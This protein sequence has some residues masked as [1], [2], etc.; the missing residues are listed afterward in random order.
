[1][2]SKELL[3]ICNANVSAEAKIDLLIWAIVLRRGYVGSRDSNCFI[4]GEYKGKTVADIKGTVRGKNYL[5]WICSQ[6]FFTRKK[7]QR[8]YEDCREYGFI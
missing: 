2:S 3:S 8:V 6:K 5:K 4:A 1:M 7:F